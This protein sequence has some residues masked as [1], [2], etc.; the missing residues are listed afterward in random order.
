MTR[1]LRSADEMRELGREIASSLQGGTV[2]GLIGPLG[3]GKTEFVRGFASHFGVGDIASP[4]FVLEAEY[5][6]KNPDRFFHHWDLYR[7]SPQFDGAELR[8]VCDDPQRIVVIE[9]A[10]KLPWLAEKLDLAIY[11]SYA[12]GDTRTVRLAHPVR[13]TEHS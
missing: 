3:A 9:W 11:L 5:Q 12:E 8:E 1:V 13:M 10:D 6:L 4:S 2:I 7:V